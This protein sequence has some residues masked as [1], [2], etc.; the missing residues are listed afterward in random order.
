MNKFAQV[1]FEADGAGGGGEPAPSGDPFVTEPTPAV[2]PSGD[3][4]PAGDIDPATQPKSVFDEPAVAPD[5]YEFKLQ[6]GLELT[7]ELEADFTAIAKEAK[8]TQEQASKLI[9]LHSKVVLDVMHKQ[10][11]IVDGW[12]AECQKQG[13]ISRENIAAAKLA[14]NT[15]GGGEAMQVLVNT[16]V[17][18]HPAIQK[19]LQNIGGLLMEDQ[20]PD[21]QAPKAKEPTDADLFFPGGGF[22]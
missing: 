3:P 4:T 8:L 2:E 17:A 13:L 10:E 11:E 22:K 9:D 19:M 18:N 15:F 5:K 21:G 7:P 12:T 20:P 6:D 1:F 16:G 14:V